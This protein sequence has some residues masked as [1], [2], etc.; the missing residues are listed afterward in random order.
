LLLLLLLLML[1]LLL[2]PTTIVCREQRV[3]T[4]HHNYATV[5]NVGTWMLIAWEHHLP[6]ASKF[7]L[8]ALLALYFL[9]S[10]PLC[11]LCCVRQRYYFFHLAISEPVLVAAVFVSLSP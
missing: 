2:P 6:L 7:Y 3:S 4:E 9:F 5:D 8:I 10:L 1:L 11:F